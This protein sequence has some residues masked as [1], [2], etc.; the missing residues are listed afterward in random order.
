VTADI[1]T[2][3]WRCSRGYAGYAVIRRRF[4]GAELI[5]KIAAEIDRPCIR[6]AAH[7]MVRAASGMAHAADQTVSRAAEGIR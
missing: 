6:R 5:S 2:R 7:C 1:R 3:L 4:A